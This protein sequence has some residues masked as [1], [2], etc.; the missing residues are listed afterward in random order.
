MNIF[1][2]LLTGLFK[3]SVEKFAE[4]KAEDWMDELHQKSPDIHAAVLHILNDAIGRLKPLAA[5]TETDF[6]DEALRVAEEI[7]ADQ[8][9]KWGI[10]LGAAPLAARNNDELTDPNQPPPPGGPGGH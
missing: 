10:S 9:N 6:D 2:K 8:A 5:S 1:V 3:G 7:L 4:Q